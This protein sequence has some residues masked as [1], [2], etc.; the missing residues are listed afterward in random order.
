MKE[1]AKCVTCHELQ[2]WHKLWG[3]FNFIDVLRLQHL[4]N[5]MQ[6]MVK[7]EVCIQVKFVQTQ[8]RRPDARAICT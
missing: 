4:V 7:V 8:S 6:I 5:G 3:H 1:K 2:T